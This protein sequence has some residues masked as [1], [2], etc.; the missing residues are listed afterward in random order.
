MVLHIFQFLNSD[1][2]SCASRVCRKWK[3]L[4]STTLNTG[5]KVITQ[6][7]IQIK[8]Y[9]S[10]NKKWVLRQLSSKGCS[11][12]VTAM[13]LLDHGK[14]INL[15]EMH[16]R[17]GG[18]TETMESDLKRAGLETTCTEF[19]VGVVDKKNQSEIIQQLSTLIKKNGSGIIPFR[20]G[21]IRHV[22]ILDAIDSD[23][24][25]FRDPALAQEITFKTQRLFELI[26]GT[27]HFLQVI[28]K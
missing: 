6:G 13:L 9:L 10:K 16:D 12:G 20:Q 7:D 14:E 21:L 19:N 23:E 17:N 11:A 22:V 25:R 18:F 3:A 27:T 15:Q 2:L 24:M 26:W 4:A 1:E 8:A 28:Q 5:V